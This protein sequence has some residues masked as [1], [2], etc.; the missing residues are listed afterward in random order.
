M[1]INLNRKQLM[2][3]LREMG[4]AFPT[5]AGRD[6]LLAILEA[7]NQ[8]QWLKAARNQ[9]TAR[10]GQIIRRR[11]DLPQGK[12]ENAAASTPAEDAA[13]SSPSPAPAL[14]IAMP[15]EVEL[16][17]RPNFHPT[18]KERVPASIYDRTQNL[19][20]TALKRADGVCELCDQRPKPGIGDAPGGLKACYFIDPPEGNPRTAK[21]VAALCPDCY[22]RITQGP[23]SAELKLLKRKARR[24]GTRE[25]AVTSKVK[26]PV[27]VPAKAQKARHHAAQ[28]GRLKTARQPHRKKS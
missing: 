6:E 19:E 7:A 11:R 26:P 24:K 20:A 27:S 2:E 15:S 10:R 21:T 14:E 1:A 13:G 9:A 5:D 25:V 22:D 16:P 18:P 3:T 12:A 23:T 28:N 17:P 4:V 8:R